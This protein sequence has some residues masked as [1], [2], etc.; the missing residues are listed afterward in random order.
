MVDKNLFPES[1]LYSI[2]RNN[3]ELD[4]K[5]AELSATIESIQKE[6]I[7]IKL[8]AQEIVNSYDQRVTEELNTTRK[9]ILNLT[10][11]I[12]SSRYTL[13]QTEIRAPVD[14]VIVGLKIFNNQGV[15]SPGED[16]LSIVPSN[17]ALIINTLVKLNDI[18]S[19]KVGMQS[20]VRFMAINQ[21]QKLPAKG[22]I[23]AISADKVFD[24]VSSDFYYKTRIEVTEDLEAQIDSTNLVPGMKAEVIINSGDT[25]LIS[26]L[27][28]PLTQSL[29]RAIT[30]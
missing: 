23:R 26:Y 16:I 27:L 7:E 24:P 8:K 6:I 3:L 10:E 25:T 13:E 18:D 9:N 28:E 1:S 21:R 11:N 30:N 4:S 12:K 5:K 2:Q 15:I 19:V 17:D 29:R 20:Q 22:I 14:G